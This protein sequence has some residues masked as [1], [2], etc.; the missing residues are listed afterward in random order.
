MKAF[1]MSAHGDLDQLSP[2]EIPAPSLSDPHQVL[3]RIKAAGLNHLDL[4]TLAGLPGISLKFPHVLGGDA[5]GIV[6]Q[7]GAGVTS[8]KPGDRVMLNPGISCYQCEYC[9]AG[10]HSLCVE[11]RILGEHLPGT[12]AEL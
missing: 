7:V 10:E 9:L 11:Y 5:A 4:W 12:L 3:V 2:G 8:V 1:L 6:E